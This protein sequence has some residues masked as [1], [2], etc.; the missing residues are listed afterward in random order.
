MFSL[1]GRACRTARPSLALLKFSPAPTTLPAPTTRLCSSST[2]PAPQPDKLYKRIE[3]ELRA[4]EP[5][6]LKSYSW[7][8]S[9]AAQELGILVSCVFL[10]LSSYCIKVESNVAVAEPHKERK[11]L[12]KAAYVNKKHRVQYE[13]RTYYHYLTGKDGVS[14]HPSN[15][16]FYNCSCAAD[17]EHGGH[18]PRVHPAQPAGGRQHEGDP[19]RGAAAIPRDRSAA[20]P[21]STELSWTRSRPDLL[22]IFCKATSRTKT[23]FIIS[24]PSSFFSISK[25]SD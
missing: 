24:Y 25:F 18:L 22:C 17:G 23:K 15:R 9:T 6:V 5:A 13:M 11:T 8:A 3:L 1:V 16:G 19:A 21:G 10:A 20:R 4:H 14:I 7:F 2:V 12:L